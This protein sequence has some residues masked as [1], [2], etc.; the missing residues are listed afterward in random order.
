MSKN[1]SSHIDIDNPD[2]PIAQICHIEPNDELLKN[3]SRFQPS[4]TG[5][6][7]ANSDRISASKRQNRQKREPIAKKNNWYKNGE[8]QPAYN[9][10]LKLLF[11]SDFYMEYRTSIIDYNYHKIRCLKHFPYRTFL[12]IS[13]LII[14]FSDISCFPVLNISVSHLITSANIAVCRLYLVIHDCT[15]SDMTI[16]GQA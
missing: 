16:P 5:T 6:I 13:R 1:C 12:T 9:S 14:Q 11:V 15:W 2:A 4:P 3:K 10:R 7:S 8:N